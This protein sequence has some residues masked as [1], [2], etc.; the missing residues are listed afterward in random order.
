VGWTY[1]RLPFSPTPRI[2]RR[3]PRCRTRVRNRREAPVEDVAPVWQQGAE[4][5]YGD[6]AALVPGTDLA[7]MLGFEAGVGTDYGLFVLDA[8]TGEER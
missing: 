3:P 8:R 6:Q 7:V 5:R 2:T 4:V 1:P